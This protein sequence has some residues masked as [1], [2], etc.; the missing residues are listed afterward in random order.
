MLANS[1][2]YSL[3]GCFLEWWMPGA[4]PLKY[5]LHRLASCTHLS[6]HLKLKNP[7]FALKPKATSLEDSEQQYYTWQAEIVTNQGRHLMSEMTKL[8]W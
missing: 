5:H 8:A 3:I 6:W 7:L 4:P 2:I 1:E